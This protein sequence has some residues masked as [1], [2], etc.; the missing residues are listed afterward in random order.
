MPLRA[1]LLAPMK[2]RGVAL[3][4]T[5]DMLALSGPGAREPPGLSETFR[6]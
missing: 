4:R 2:R 3:Y 1:Y 5:V 6:P